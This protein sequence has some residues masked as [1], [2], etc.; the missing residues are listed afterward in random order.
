MESTGFNDINRS[1]YRLEL[2]DLSFS[3]VLKGLVAEKGKGL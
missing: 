2:N 3:K 1:H